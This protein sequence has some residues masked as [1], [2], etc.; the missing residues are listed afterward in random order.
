[1]Y[2]GRV[3]EQAQVDDLF[4]KPEMPYTWG[5]WARCRAS[6]CSRR[7]ARA[8][9]WPAAV[10]LRPPSGCPFNPRCEY[11]IASAASSFPSWSRLR[12]ATTT[13]TAAIDDETRARIWQARGSRALR[14]DDGDGA[15]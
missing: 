2:G 4:V 8:V 13:G 3:V 14:D 15:G 9:S 11:V 10:P 12:S 7:T 5:C 6:N 1:M